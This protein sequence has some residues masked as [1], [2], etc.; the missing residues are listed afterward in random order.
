LGLEFR[1]Y[2]RADAM[3]CTI[4]HATRAKTVCRLGLLNRKVIR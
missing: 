3:R 2:K 1:R 4:V